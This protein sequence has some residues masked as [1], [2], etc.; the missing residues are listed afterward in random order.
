MKFKDGRSLGKSAIAPFIPDEDP[1]DRHKR[2]KDTNLFF[3][4]DLSNWCN[5]NGWKFEI[6]NDAH[7]WIF[8]KNKTLVE[9]WPSS[10]KLVKDKQWKKGIHCH[11]Y[12]KVINFLKKEKTL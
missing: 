1:R 2:R 10:A 12:L 11:D 8:R 4:H 6:K 3:A 9:W 7:H 5:E